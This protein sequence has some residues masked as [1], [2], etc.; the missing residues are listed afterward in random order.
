[1][2][3]IK[4]L[5]EDERLCLRREC[6]SNAIGGGLPAFDFRTT[7]EEQRGGD[8]PGGVEGWTSVDMFAVSTYDTLKR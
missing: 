1:M 5:K 8:G 3:D 7:E 4:S 2:R 6:A